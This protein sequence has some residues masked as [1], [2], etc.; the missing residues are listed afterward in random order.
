MY[1]M[2]VTVECDHCHD[3]AFVTSTISNSFSGDIRG[4]L[5][6]PPGWI[7]YA[8]MTFC[9]KADCIEAWK[10]IFADVQ[11]SFRDAGHF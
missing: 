1:C 9:S 8:P 11:K 3:T 5:R 10:K 2:N 4:T 7:D 6:V